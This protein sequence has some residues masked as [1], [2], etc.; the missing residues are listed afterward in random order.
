MMFSSLSISP[1][2]KSDKEASLL[3]RETNEHWRVPT[4]GRTFGRHPGQFRIQ[5]QCTGGAQ[6][7]KPRTWHTMAMKTEEL[8][9]NQ[10]SPRNVNEAGTCWN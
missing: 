3:P 5:H 2:H 6:Y 8:K 1:L 7:P 9:K 10:P 4:L